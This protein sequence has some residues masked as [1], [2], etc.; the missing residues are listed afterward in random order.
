MRALT[1]TFDTFAK[2]SADAQFAH[3]RR[4]RHRRPPL[5]SPRCLAWCG[6]FATDRNIR[7]CRHRAHPRAPRKYDIFL[8]QLM[9]CSIFVLTPSR[10]NTD[11]REHRNRPPSPARPLDRGAAGGAAA[12]GQ[13]KVRREGRIVQFL[14][15]GVSIAEIAAREGVTEKRMR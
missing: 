9:D 15:R 7:P 8:R 4:P 12:Q 11:V 13:A 1:V 5:K 6:I 14:N 2:P 3:S 10:R